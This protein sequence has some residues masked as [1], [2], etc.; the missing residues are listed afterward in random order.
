MKADL[1]KGYEVAFEKITSK[2]TNE[3]TS[4]VPY[5]VESNPQVTGDDLQDARVQIDQEKNEPYVSLE[6]KAQGA[7]RFEDVTGANIGKQLAVILDGNIYTAPNIQSKIGGGRAKL[8]W[9][10]GISINL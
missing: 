6:F 1:P 2:T 8:R 5:V 4:M 3:I 9:G 7:K 10:P